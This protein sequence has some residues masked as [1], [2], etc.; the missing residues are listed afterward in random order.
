MGA[1]SAERFVLFTDGISGRF[2]L[3]SLRS[4]SSAE[5]ATHIFASHRHSHDDASVVVVDV[6]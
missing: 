5:L 6:S 1:P 4:H 2:D 3:K